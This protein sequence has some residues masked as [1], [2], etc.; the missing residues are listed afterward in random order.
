VRNQ[1]LDRGNPY[2]VVAQDAHVL[3][4]VFSRLEQKVRGNR[5]ADARLDKLNQKLKTCSAKDLFAQA[6]SVSPFRYWTEFSDTT[7]DSQGIA[8]YIFEIG[9]LRLESRSG[10]QYLGIRHESV[11]AHT[12]RAAQI[13]V[14]M[15]ILAEPLQPDLGGVNPH[16]VAAEVIVH[17]NG[18]ARIQDANRVAK[19]YVT[20][21]EEDAVVH[22]ASNLGEI[23]RD[24]IA[25]WKAVEHRSTASGAISKDVDRLEMVIEA[26]NLVRHGIPAARS[27]ID[28][29]KPMICTEI[30]KALFAA[31]EA[32]L[33]A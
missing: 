17:E 16:F 30:G 15:A 23:G 12:F 21:R 20:P 27:W 22:Q 6:R 3:S 18:E 19:H 28:N 11:A 32:A 5:G 2:S 24:I 29:T 7:P 9:K 31:V 10:W 33:D 25:K 26:A 13:G 14:M 4:E 1:T 8:D